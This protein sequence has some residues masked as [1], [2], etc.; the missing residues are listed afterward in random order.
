[1]NKNKIYTAVL[2]MAASLSFLYWIVLVA[3]NLHVISFSLVW[4][5]LALGLAALAR[6]VK[7][8]IRFSKNVRVATLCVLVLGA[9]VSIVNLC[10]IMTPVVNDGSVETKYVILL[11]GG[12]KK[13]GELSF[14]QME[15]LKS[16]VSYLD[17]HPGSK[18]IVSGGKCLL[19]DY[20][21]AEIMEE[22]LVKMGVSPWQIIK[23]DESQD[24]IENL[25]FSAMIIADKNGCSVQSAMQEPV[26]VV[27]SFFHLAR[28]ER[29]AKRLGYTH[30]YGIGA[31]TP[32]YNVLNV[33]VR[34]ICS[35]VKLN[36]RILLTGEPSHL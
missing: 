14:N 33:Y 4:L 19:Q 35:Y 11:G 17:N 20:V 25:K 15:R 8:N 18:I 32:L 12:V 28:A 5:F 30:V 24:T 21:E 31:K 13:N 29:I 27:T 10:F 36:L 26:T 7:N 22:N 34:E 9:A 1:M 23:E 2:L 16:A 3:A 6:C